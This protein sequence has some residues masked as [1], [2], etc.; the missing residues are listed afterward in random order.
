MVDP[1]IGARILERA[2]SYA[3]PQQTNLQHRSIV[4]I[5]YETT[6]DRED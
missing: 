2:Q 5:D 6:Q 1:V 4:Q 3:D